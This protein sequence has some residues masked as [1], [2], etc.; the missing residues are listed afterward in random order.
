M[1]DGLVRGLPGQVA[2]ELGRRIVSGDLPEGAR[3]DVEDRLVEQFGV[4]RTVIREA[5]KGLGAKGLIQVR[6]RLG[7][8]V[9]PRK[10]WNLLDPDVMHWQRE[11][12]PSMA[13]LRQLRE[14][15][16]IVEPAAAAL[17]AE[18]CR[19]PAPLQAAYGKMEQT[20]HDPH[21]FAV[22]DAALHIEILHAA[23]NDYLDAL[24]GLILTDLLSSIR[25]TN[26]DRDRNS[27][28][29]PLHRAVVDA[30]VEGDREEAAAAM[31]ALLDNSARRLGEAE[32]QGLQKDGS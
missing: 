1:H 16:S 3:L 32:K 20:V 24:G 10:R 5:I 30:I 12:P 6:P 4:S 23:D 15:R 19:R 13:V 29:L 2:R 22:A 21:A 26:P 9:L 7:T 17:A 25:I 14:M 8:S 11:A 27:R 28:S 18:R 31:R